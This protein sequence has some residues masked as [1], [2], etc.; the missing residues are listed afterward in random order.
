MDIALEIL[1]TFAFDY[2]YAALLPARSA[3]YGLPNID[4]GGN[5]TALS[6]WTYKPTSFLFTLEPSRYAY[7]SAWPRDK[8]A[9]QYISLFLITW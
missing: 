1:D 8:L 9:R 6:A 5:A 3:P 2:A 7:M 4:I